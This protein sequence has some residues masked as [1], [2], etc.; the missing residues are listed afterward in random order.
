MEEQRH[1]T[2]SIALVTTVWLASASTARDRAFTS[3]PSRHADVL[4]AFLLYHLEIGIAKIFVFVDG[5]ERSQLCVD[6]LHPQVQTHYATGLIE[7]RYRDNTSSTSADDGNESLYEL[8]E[9]HCV[10]FS[11]FRDSMESDVVARQML[12]AELAMHLCRQH[13]QQLKPQTHS[14]SQ[15]QQSQLQQC[16]KPAVGELRWLLHLDVDE[17]LYLDA[18][19]TEKKSKQALSEYVNSLEEQQHAH[20]MTI[21][22]Y[23]AIPTRLYGGNYFTT[24]TKF[25]RHHARIPLTSDAQRGVAFW[26]QRARH[27]QFF[28]FYDNGKSM[29]RVRDDESGVSIH[30]VPASVHHWRVSSNKPSTNGSVISTSSKTNFHDARRNF[31]QENVVN[32]P[33]GQRACILHYPVCGLEWLNEKYER[34][35]KFP[36]VWGGTSSETRRRPVQIRP[37]F[38]TQ[39]RDALPQDKS[40]SD[41]MRELYE[42]HV[43][44]DMDAHAREWERQVAAGV[45]EEIDFVAQV[46]ASLGFSRQV[47]DAPPSLELTAAAAGK[48]HRGEEGQC[49]SGGSSLKPTPAP[50]ASP[51]SFTTEKAWMLASIS[52]QYL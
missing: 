35:G 32:E 45:C 19:A 23:E 25:R 52:S 2:S 37:C 41:A 16:T 20:Q 18:F 1:Q 10:D 47:M 30:S 27:Q 38:H 21:V 33:L 6:E 17:L 5:D 50:G 22:N 14:T 49:D 11:R 3:T 43:L 8:Y 34:L 29:V 9:R 15:Q 48:G 51:E 36:D 31:A 39:A 4:S 26:Q 42:S 12:N 44:L 28:L 24:A 13:N 40:T 46:L 7:L